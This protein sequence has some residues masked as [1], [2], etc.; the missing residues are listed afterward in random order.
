MSERPWY[1]A[2]TRTH[3]CGSCANI[4]LQTLFFVQDFPLLGDTVCVHF[5]R[6]GFALAF[7][8]V[9]FRSVAP[10]IAA[11]RPRIP[12]S[13]AIVAQ[14][15]DARRIVASVNAERVSHLIAPLRVDE[16][17]AAVA[18]AHALDMARRSYF[19]HVSLSGAS[20]FE[21]LDRARYAYEWAGEN[22]ALDSGPDSA[23]DALWHSLEHRE[24][25]LEPHFGR[26]GV[27][28]VETPGGEIVVEDFTD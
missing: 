20:P 10:A 1:K 17:L 8:A 26:V 18:L 27:G 2:K 25:T 14:A 12:T 9:S 4:S 7:A 15:D 21:R 11:E 24:N 3:V 16:R 28:A 6:L 19:G 13:G 22:L 5:V 23:V